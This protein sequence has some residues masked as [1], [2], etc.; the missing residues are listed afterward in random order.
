MKCELHA[1]TFEHGHAARHSF[2]PGAVMER[3]RLRTAL[4]VKPHPVEHPPHYTAGKVECIDAIESATEGLTGVEGFGVG[5]VIKYVW[6][7]KR[8]G[9]L[10]DLKK[11]RW[12]LDRLIAHVEAS[13][14]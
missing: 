11:C 7:W 12:Y 13:R 3:D 8:K 5:Q 1:C 2:E 9:G 14:G 6:R 4:A 10:E